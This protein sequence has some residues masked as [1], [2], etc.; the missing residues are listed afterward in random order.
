M[1]NHILY[2]EYEQIRSLVPL[3]IAAASN[4]AW[5]AYNHVKLALELT[6]FK[7]NLEP[8]HNSSPIFNSEWSSSVYRVYIK[9]IT[10]YNCGI[11]H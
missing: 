4:T 9:E 11:Q 6:G 1:L 3:P 8:E 7:F 10:K 2:P 5:F